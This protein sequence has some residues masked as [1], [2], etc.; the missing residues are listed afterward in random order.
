MH[1]AVYITVMGDV[2]LP[3]F[4]N[5]KYGDGIHKIDIMH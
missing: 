4:Q 2:C 5:C 3:I 1:L